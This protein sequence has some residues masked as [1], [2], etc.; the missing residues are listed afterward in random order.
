MPPTARAIQR[1]CG[2][3]RPVTG[4]LSEIR[5]DTGQGPERTPLSSTLC[6]PL[7]N[8]DEGPIPLRTADY[9]WNSCG[10]LAKR[11]A[12]TGSTWRRIRVGSRQPPRRRLV[13]CGAMCDGSHMATNLAIDP[14]LLERA[15]RVSGAKSKTAAVTLALTE[16]I[17]RR[18]QARLLDL[19]GSLTW[20]PSFDYKSERKRR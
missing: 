20:D 1:A 11:W 4:Q 15:R 13:L 17:A 6:K 5:P 9:R 3:R 14:D 2:S 12:R 7:R 16:F 18:E 10:H 8:L 19:F